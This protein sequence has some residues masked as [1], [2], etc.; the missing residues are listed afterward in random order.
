MSVRFRTACLVLLFPVGLALPG[1]V[2]ISAQQTVPSSEA[3]R[4]SATGADVGYQWYQNKADEWRS[5][6]RLLRTAQVLFVAVAL[7]SSVLA[8]SRIVFPKWWPEWLLPV[9]AALAIALFTGL[10]I[11]SQANKQR[12]AWR[13]LTG[14]LAEYRDGDGRIDLVRKAYIEAEEIIGSYN[15]QAP[16]K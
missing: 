6:A 16:K 7:I 10:D 2:A 15:P 11:N 13:H 14:A 3:R 1:A 5:E 12:E 9:A 8:A 4:A